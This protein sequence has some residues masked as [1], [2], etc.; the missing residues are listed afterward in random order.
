MPFALMG[1]D[2]DGG[3]EF[4]DDQLYRYCDHEGITFT[5]GRAGKKN[6]QAHVEQ[7]NDSVIR[8]WLG[9]GRY[10]TPEQIAAINAFYW[11]LRLYSNFFLPVQKRTGKEHIG[12]RVKR[13]YG[14]PRTPRQRILLDGSVPEQTK[15]EL[16]ALYASLDLVALKQRLDDSRKRVRPTRFG[17]IDS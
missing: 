7:K 9:Y 2:S 15:E 10:D 4:I 6:D 13:T 5:R 11:Y 14:E 16:E 12:S 3:A 17:K 1:I 8:R